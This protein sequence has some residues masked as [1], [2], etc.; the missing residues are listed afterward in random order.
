MRHGPESRRIGLA[1][2][3]RHWHILHHRLWS[4]CILFLR[5]WLWSRWTCLLTGQ[6]WSWCT[7]LPY[8]W[9]DEEFW[10][11]SKTSSWVPTHG[12]AWRKAPLHGCGQWCRT[13]KNWIELRWHCWTNWLC[14]SDA[15]FWLTLGKNWRYCC[16]RSGRDEIHL[17]GLLI[18]RPC[19]ALES[20]FT[21]CL[22]HNIMNRISHDGRKANKSMRNFL[23]HH[24]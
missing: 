22:N 21:K 11:H 18:G 8:C 13:C 3:L 24:I 16:S 5:N 17:A 6:L 12:I 10:R 2:W 15:P 7:C 4:G 14:N 20:P 9:W 1:R 23:M 19:V